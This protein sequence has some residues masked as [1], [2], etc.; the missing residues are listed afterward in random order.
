VLEATRQR[1]IRRAIPTL[2]LKII[3]DIEASC[4]DREGDYREL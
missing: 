2:L 3:L 4:G 1:L